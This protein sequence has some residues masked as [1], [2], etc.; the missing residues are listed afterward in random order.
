MF[1][2][3][4]ASP[5]KT[6]S[7]K[8]PVAIGHSDSRTEGLISVRAAD[9][10]NSRQRGMGEDAADL[11]SYKKSNNSA[12]AVVGCRHIKFRMAVRTPT[13]HRRTAR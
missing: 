13:P 4:R 2:G 1:I 9:P 5:Q 11:K 12:N 7:I 10:A 3:G 8:T 6:S